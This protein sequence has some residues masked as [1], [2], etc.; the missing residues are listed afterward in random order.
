MWPEGI[1]TQPRDLNTCVSSVCMSSL[2]PEGI[3]TQPRDLNTERHQ[4]PHDR[5]KA[6]RHINPA[7]GFKHL[8]ANDGRIQIRARRHINPA[9]GFKHDHR[10]RA[11]RLEKGPE[12]I[13]TQPRD[14]NQHVT[15][16]RVGR[17]G[18]R[19]H[20]NPAEGFKL[21]LP[22]MWRWSATSASQK[23]YQPS[24]GI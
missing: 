20:I 6:R 4:D 9:E 16:L 21:P 7:E 11:A 18:A 13:S 14:L 24:R 22:S 3:S 1:S 8:S 12:G 17:L 15:V 19:R 5:K 10:T 23:A 2:L